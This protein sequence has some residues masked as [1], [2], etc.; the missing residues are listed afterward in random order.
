MLEKPTSLLSRRK[1]L[2]EVY[3]KWTVMKGAM[4][5]EKQ[6]AGVFAGVQIFQIHVRVL[7]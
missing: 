7:P 6:A 5:L 4:V 2:E 1:I 3:K